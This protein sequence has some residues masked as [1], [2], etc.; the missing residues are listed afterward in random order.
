MLQCSAISARPRPTR[1]Y[2]LAS[3]PPWAV[4]CTEIAS[5]QPATDIPLGERSFVKRTMALSVVVVAVLVLA[6]PG[7]RG[8]ERAAAAGGD[9]TET[10]AP[11]TP[12]PAPTD[13][14]AMTQT[15]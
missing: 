12:Q 2:R 14:E 11:A 1:K 10:I 4:H 7:C 15:V 3:G 8:R 13:T 5:G 9:S 6:S